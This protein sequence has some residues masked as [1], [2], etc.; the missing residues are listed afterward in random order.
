MV[1]LCRARGDWIADRIGILAA[2]RNGTQM[3]RKQE[4]THTPKS[5]KRSHTGY[6][7]M[8]MSHARMRKDIKRILEE[9]AKTGATGKPKHQIR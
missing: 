3:A 9:R 1:F 2:S 7:K 5:S 6:E 4:I 8:Q